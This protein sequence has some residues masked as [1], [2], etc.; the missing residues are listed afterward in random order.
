MFTQIRFLENYQVPE[1]VD[2]E[3]RN[4]VQFITSFEGLHGNKILEHAPEFESFLRKY[5]YEG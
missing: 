4:P 3:R 1:N 2:S 5:G